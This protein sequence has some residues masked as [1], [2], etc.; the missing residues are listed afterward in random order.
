PGAW[1]RST[2]PAAWR[3][4]WPR[5]TWCR[6]GWRRSSTASRWPDGSAL[7]LLGGRVEALFQLPPGV[8]GAVAQL[9]PGVAARV[10]ELVDLLAVL[11]ALGAELVDLLLQ[12]GLGRVG[13]R[14]Q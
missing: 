9:L 5:W 10:L 14:G 1:R 4:C 6:A 7:E 8:A 13:G 12:L 2:R 11:V 3:A